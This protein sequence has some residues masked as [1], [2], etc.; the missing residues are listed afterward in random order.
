MQLQS[1][2]RTSAGG[3]ESEQ[4]GKTGDNAGGD[5]GERE[6]EKERRKKRSTTITPTDEEKEKN[7][8][9]LSSSSSQTSL[10]SFLLSPIAI[11][12]LQ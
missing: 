2:E 1:R 12:M 4:A 9:A 5:E 7:S 10:P 11:Q 6:R 8:S 3:E